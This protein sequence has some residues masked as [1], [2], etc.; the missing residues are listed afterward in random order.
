MG[1]KSEKNILVEK[2]QKLNVV[3]DYSWNDKGFSAVFAELFKDFCRY[4][5]TAKE[6]Y[7]FDGKI[8]ARDE[9]AM[10]TSRKAKVFTD[11]LFLYAASLEDDKRELFRA[12]EYSVPELEPH[13]SGLTE[14]NERNDCLW[15]AKPSPP[16]KS[17]WRSWRRI[18][19]PML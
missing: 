18:A 9:G 2:M 19:C 12:V 5:T 8:W 11:A 4:N 17:S 16:P 14:K 13:F 1:E 10:K 3:K 7:C 6:W 15:I